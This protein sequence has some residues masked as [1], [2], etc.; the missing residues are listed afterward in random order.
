MYGISFS[1]L[2][3]FDEQETDR[4]HQF[5]A[6]QRPGVLDLGID[7]AGGGTVRDLLLHM[8]A[9][10][11]KYAE[12]VSGSALTQLSDLPTGTIDEIFSIATKAQGKM[13]TYLKTASEAEL[14]GKIT[15]PTLSAGE[16]T[17]TR[18]KVLGHALIHSLRHWAQLTTEMR[19]RGYKTDWHH[20]F[21][22]TDGL[23]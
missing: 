9:V 3:R 20:D 12:R 2:L 4:W 19:R 6:K 22:F 18:R 21:L 11:L 8:F 14:N 15:F 23:T 16:Q 17:A 5:L 1:E 7:L 10:E 13:K